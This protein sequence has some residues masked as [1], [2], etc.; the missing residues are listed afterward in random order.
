M[1]DKTQL[2]AGGSSHKKRNRMARKLNT[3]QG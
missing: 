1:T 2:V 3:K